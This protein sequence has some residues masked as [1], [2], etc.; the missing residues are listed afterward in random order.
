MKNMNILVLEDDPFQRLVA[1]TVLRKLG[2][3]R[4]HEATDGAEA[5]RVL[6][7]S[8]DVDIA[9]CDLRMA[10]MDGLAFLRQASHVGGIR[11]VILSS[12]VEPAL[13][14]ATQS[15]IRC[16][17]LNYLGDLG[18]PVDIDRVAELLDKYRTQSPP[19]KDRQEQRS[20]PPLEDVIRGLAQGEFEAYFQPK[21]R[22]SN[23][24][25]QGAEVLARW[26]HP[27]RGILPPSCFLPQMETHDLLDQC[28]WQL[29]EQGLAVQRELRASGRQIN[30][31]FNVEAAQLGQP[32]FADRIQAAL[33]AVNLPG[34]GVTF[35]LTETKLLQAPANSLES[36]VRLRLLGCGLA[37]DDFGTGY[38]S[39]DRLR[40]LPFNQMKLDAAFVRNLMH[41]PRSSAIISSTV[42]LA[43]AMDIA[44]VVEG[45]ETQEQRERLLALGCDIAQGYLFARP[46]DRED[47]LTLLEGGIPPAH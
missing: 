1:V 16:L 46:V 11:S 5:L 38:S 47:F 4:I 26:R 25:L 18:K 28:F 35:E 23:G 36:L 32:G 40:K 15:M 17:G 42:V 24:Q 31:A 7:T 12:A 13:R 44:L 2:V 14:D 10:G 37:M 41:Q 8:G 6:E 33:E 27:E 20:P 29:F 45:V 30:L 22:M 43:E 19:P 39:L 3:G 21:V 34:T 9:W